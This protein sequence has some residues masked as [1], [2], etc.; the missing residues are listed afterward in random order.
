M[1]VAVEFI[2]K[3][4]L[5]A[6]RCLRGDYYYNDCMIC[7]DSCAL[8][9]LEI[10][11]GKLALDAQLC[12]GCSACLGGCPT[13]AI[14]ADSFDPTLTMLRLVEQEPSGLKPLSCGSTGACLAGFDAHHLVIGS[15]K[16]SA[17]I[18]L[19]TAQCKK[20]S[21]NAGDLVTGMLLE[22]CEN[23][24]AMLL[25]LGFGISVRCSDESVKKSRRG[26]LFSA[27][28]SA[29]KP[30]SDEGEQ[31]RALFKQSVPLK[32]VTL[33]N[34]LRALDEEKLLSRPSSGH[35]M[36]GNKRVEPGCTNCRK[37]AEF[38]PTDALSYTSDYSS[39]MFQSSKCVQCGICEAVCEPNVI[40]E[41]APP[42][43]FEY[44][45]GRG[46]TLLQIRYVECESCKVSFSQVGDERVCPRCKSFSAD[47]ST[48]F[49]TADELSGK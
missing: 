31:K 24:N 6:K 14:G 20:C 10:Q 19:Q 35:S 36:I 13:E 21:L 42:S 3:I 33:Q 7:M 32:A 8:G 17:D 45:F 29:V 34:T 47:F 48:M 40:R 38:C 26:F 44:A 18:V 39:L 43:F 27:A 30:I 25:E 22:R 2:S 15:I 49:M 16:T 4:S 37:C 12:V 1:S 5:D 23:A 28:K 46:T 11:R 9:A 41:E